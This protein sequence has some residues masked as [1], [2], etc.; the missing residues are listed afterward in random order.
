MSASRNNIN[1]GSASRIDR[2]Y[3]PHFQLPLH[4]SHSSSSWS[5]ILLLLR[6]PWLSLPRRRALL[7]QRRGL[8]LFHVSV[9]HVFRRAHFLKHTLV[10]GAQASRFG[11]LLGLPSPASLT[12]GQ[13]YTVT[14]DYAC[15]FYFGQ[16]PTF[17]D[18][19]LQVTANGNGHQPSILVARRTPEV[20]A[21]QPTDTFTF[22][23]P[24]GYYLATASYSLSTIVTYPVNGTNGTPVLQQGGVLNGVTI[25]DTS[26]GN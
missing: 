7:F 18:Y 23:V 19:V 4:P 9:A 8:L 11:N 20:T 2:N 21:A 16:P 6:P 3:L 25:V 17:T 15:A 5:T 1:T 22:T 14:H 12:T 26:V 24:F 10:S 13:S